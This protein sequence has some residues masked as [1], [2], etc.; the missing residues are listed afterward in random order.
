MR[1]RDLRTI[2]DL[3][4]SNYRI[5]ALPD[6]KYLHQF[7]PATT[8]TVYEFVA[9]SSPVLTEGD[10]YNIGFYVT[11]NGRNVVEV[12]ALGRSDGVDKNLS[13]QVAKKISLDKRDENVAKNDQRVRHEGGGD[14]YWGRKYAWRQYG[15]AV[16]K[17]AFYNYLEEIGHPSIPCITSNPDL[18]YSANEESIAYADQG[19][20]A[21]MDRL[22]SSAVKDG[23]YFTSPLYSRKFKIRPLNSI[24]D[25]K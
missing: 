10:R 4:V 25:K 18:P 19:L 14:Y 11:P 21:A 17:D 23:R 20:E 16:A 1:S 6:G 9:N 5:S 2:H 8:D 13:Y 3:I 12:T 7:T 22:I 24:T 15:L